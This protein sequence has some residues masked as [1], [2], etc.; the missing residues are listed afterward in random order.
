M[1]AGASVLGDSAVGEHWVATDSWNFSSFFLGMV[2]EAYIFG[3][4]TIATGWVTMPTSLRSL[5]L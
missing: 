2:L 5:L 1:A 3:M 4:A